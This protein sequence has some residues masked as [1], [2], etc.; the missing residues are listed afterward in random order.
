M[1][2]FEYVL[3][4]QIQTDVISLTLKYL[5]N[6]INEN[7]EKNLI[8]RINIQEFLNN[9]KCLFFFRNKK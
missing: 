4:H 5:Y 1:H 2:I 7:Q 8:I 6:F 9:K 3:V